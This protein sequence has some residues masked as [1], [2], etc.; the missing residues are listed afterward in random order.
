MGPMKTPTTF[1]G[2]VVV[3]S[4]LA[5]SPSLTMEGARVRVAQGAN[6]DGNCRPI[7]NVDVQAGDQE[8]A[9]IL[10]RNK[11][12]EM[13]ANM[14]TVAE[15]VEAGGDVKLIGKSYSCT[16][17]AGGGQQATEASAE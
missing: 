1:L 8:D 12:G 10:L 7:S 13:N 4:S 2:F 16:E 6:V 5:C 11:A 15:K 17:G 3:L 14:V 9:E